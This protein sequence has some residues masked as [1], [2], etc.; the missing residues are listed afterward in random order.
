MRTGLDFD[1]VFSDCGKLKS[2]GAKQLYGVDILPAQFK[3]ELVIGGGLLT[4]E[5][6]RALQQR[7]YGTREMGLLMDPVP[8]V[9]DHLPKLLADGHDVRVITSRTGTELEIAK[10]WSRLQGLQLAFTGTGYGNS[11]ADAASGLDLFVDDDLDKL[12]PLVGIVPHLFLFSWGYNE[13][14]EAAPVAKRVASWDELYLA[15]C[16]VNALR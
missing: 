4:T 9:I 13:H 3:K 6:Y 1:G 2:K 7:I 11:K 8:G 15:I 10:E 5:Q 14:V 16:E 12:A